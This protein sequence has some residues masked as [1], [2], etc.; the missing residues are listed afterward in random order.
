MSEGGAFFVYQSQNADSLASCCRLRN[1]ISDHS[2]SY[3]LGAGGVAT[4]S[5]N[6]IT[7]NMNRLIQDKRD[8][9][10]EIV[11]VQKYQIAYRKLME[12][13]LANGMLPVYDAGFISLDKQFLTIGINGMVEAAEYLGLTANTNTE[14]QSLSRIT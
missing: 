9:H 5:I 10:T 3:S 13:H 11:K 8:L 1:E 12:D 14:Y 4:G 6:V 7:V 2:F